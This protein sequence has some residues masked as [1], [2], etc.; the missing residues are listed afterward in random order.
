MATVGIANS[1]NMMVW[2]QA[3]GVFG[4]ILSAAISFM[5]VLGYNAAWSKK[6]EMNATS[7]EKT[8]SLA[9]LAAFDSD[10]FDDVVI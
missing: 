1:I 7:A 5:R 4:G 6:E 9:A 3:V 10:I 2:A 8:A